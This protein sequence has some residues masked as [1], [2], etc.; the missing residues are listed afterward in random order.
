M[1]DWYGHGSR[2]CARQRRPVATQASCLLKSLPLNWFLERQTRQCQSRHI[3]AKV[4]VVP[5]DHRD[6]GPRYLRHREQVE[7]VVYEVTDNTVAQRVCGGS[8]R[9]F[10]CFGSGL[11]RPLPSILVPCFAVNA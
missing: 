4:T 5:F 8:V 10:G 3:T 1:T 9:Q 6:A 11:D 7:S 2:P